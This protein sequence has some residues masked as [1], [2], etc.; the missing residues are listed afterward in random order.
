MRETLLARAREARERAYA[1]YSRFQVGAALEAQD[2]TVFLGCNVENASYGL[3]VC[4]ERVAVGNAVAAGH[5]SFRRLA[6]STRAPR[7]TP[8]CGACRQVLAE[9]A[10]ELEIVSEA[11]PVGEPAPRDPAGPTTGEAE[12]RRG[13]RGGTKGEVGD[14]S[15]PPAPLRA[16]WRL[17]ELLP[18]RF[19]MERDGEVPEHILG[20]TDG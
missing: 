7:P 18:A 3:T 2:G 11:L 4:A 8:P 6:L 16:E 13:L 12:G 1:P 20:R 19:R 10:P 14:V 9:F 5:R 15:S 17:D